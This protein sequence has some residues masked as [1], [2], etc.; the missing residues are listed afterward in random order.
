MRRFLIKLIPFLLCILAVAALRYYVTYDSRYD[1]YSISG[2]PISNSLVIVGDSKTLFGIDE[3]TLDHQDFYNLSSWGARPI[4]TI[5]ALESFDLTDNT[6]IMSVSSRI[7]LQDDTMALSDNNSLYRVFDFNLYHQAHS[8][9]LHQSAGRWEYTRQA[10]GSLQFVDNI[11]T[12]SA[13]SAT[14]D[15]TFYGQYVH[16][17]NR[18]FYV[19]IK[20]QHFA[21]LYKELIKNNRI[22]LVDLPERN[23]FNKLVVEFE[24]MLFEKIT[25]VTGAQV[26][27]FG[28]YPDECFYDSHH[29]NSIGARRF[30]EELKERFLR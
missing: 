20:V 3:K 16:A 30:S 29:M 24:P 15:T 7:F 6:I 12:Y 18:D 11:R 4:N 28:T 8:Y 23:A 26:Y 5:K 10:G 27:D 9:F 2:R 14:K 17:V 21:R 19:D 13:Y 25:A 1:Y 22:I